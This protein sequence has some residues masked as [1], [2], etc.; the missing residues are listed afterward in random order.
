MHL[1]HAVECITSICI[2]VLS[3]CL[4]HQFSTPFQSSLFK[5]VSPPP[6][7]LKVALSL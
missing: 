4:Y 2:A 1:C 5:K 6:P 3:V 7:P